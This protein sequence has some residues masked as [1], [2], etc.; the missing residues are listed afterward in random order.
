VYKR[1]SYNRDGDKFPATPR[2]TV[3][4]LDVQASVASVKLTADEWIDYMHLVKI[5][6]Q[7]TVINVLWAY[8]DQDL[9]R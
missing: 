6:D 4:I 5:N 8:H 1:Q 7:W 9:H 3:E 2:K